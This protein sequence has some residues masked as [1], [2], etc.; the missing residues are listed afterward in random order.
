MGLLVYIWRFS[1]LHRASVILESHL[2]L[3]VNV[4]LAVLS[5]ILPPHCNDLLPCEPRSWVRIFTRSLWY[6]LI[7]SFCCPTRWKII[8]SLSQLRKCNLSGT[9]IVHNRRIGRAR[10]VH[11]PFLWSSSKHVAWSISGSTLHLNRIYL[12]VIRGKFMFLHN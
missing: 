9:A 2:T 1:S 12:Y 8:H 4:I 7:C 11:R 6:K 5:S 10:C 3:W